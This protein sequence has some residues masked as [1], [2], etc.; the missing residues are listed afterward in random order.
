MEVCEGPVF[1]DILLSMVKKYFNN[2]RNS[3]ETVAHI[4]F[5]KMNLLLRVLDT[6]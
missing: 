2:T 6:F 3:Y 4:R 5:M 1:Q